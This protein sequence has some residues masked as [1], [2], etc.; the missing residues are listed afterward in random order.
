MATA[1]AAPT[2]PLSLREVA[3]VWAAHL[4]CFVLPVACLTF[5]LTGP[6]TGW[7]AA[8]WLLVL[9][10][11]VVADMHSPAE[12]R[13]PAAT[14]P[15]W[16]FDW[17]LWVLSALHFLILGLFVWR[18]S[19]HGFWTLDTF[20]GLS[21]IGVN[22][23]YSGIVVAHELLHRPQAHLHFL[24]RLLMGS[25]LYEHFATEHIR[26]H[27]SRVGTPEDPAT[28]RFGET[29]LQFF[30][31]TVPAQFRSAWRLEKKRLGDPDMR[32]SDPRM[33]RHRVLQGLVAEWGVAFAIWITLGT[34][35]FFA[36]FLV[37]SV[38]IR[39]LEAVN[40]FEHW[41]LARRGKRVTP[42]DSWDT[43]SR[44]T[45]Y[46][47]VGLSRHAD[48]HAWASRPYQQLRFWD[49][50]P[51]L[52]YGYFGTVVLLLVRNRRFRELMTRELERRRLGPFADADAA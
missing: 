36:Y 7:S 20:V 51:K 37:A 35:A 24:G 45:L 16:P 31:R 41:G 22:A 33:L 25:V 34:G 12:H 39:L 38:A 48:H 28:A 5:L 27:H 1:T 21:L 17:V 26:G 3:T 40:Y 6:W 43:D 50:S 9:V 4:L 49:E 18:V 52:P 47:L 23:G 10:A 46:T 14:L 11:S 44:F 30:Y 15:G 29:Y 8:A 2:Q 13:Q 42:V 19:V 32:W